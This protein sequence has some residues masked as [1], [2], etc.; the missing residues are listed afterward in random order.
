MELVVACP[1]DWRVKKWAYEIWKPI[2]LDPTKYEKVEQSEYVFYSA[3]DAKLYGKRR[4]KEI[5]KC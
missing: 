2:T 4:I 3:T 5:E 1:Y